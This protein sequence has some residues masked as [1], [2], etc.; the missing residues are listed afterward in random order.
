MKTKTIGESRAEKLKTSLGRFR[1]Q[2][3]EGEPFEE[4]DSR[5]RKAEERRVS[6][7]DGRADVQVL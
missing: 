1:H 6:L 4:G 3:K 2:G 5:R 7:S